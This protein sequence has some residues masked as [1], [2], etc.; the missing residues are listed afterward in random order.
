[1][2]TQHFIP[3]LSLLSMLPCVTHAQTYSVKWSAFSGGGGSIGK[4]SHKATAFLGDPFVGSSH[5][6]IYTITSGFGS[7]LG[8]QPTAGAPKLSLSRGF[9][10]VEVSWPRPAAGWVLETTSTLTGTATR[11]TEVSQPYQTDDTHVFVTFPIPGE[12]AYFRLR[13]P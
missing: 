13:K 9:G 10:F 12:N 11:W 1:M 6:G 2:K 5:G 3:L 7:V 4:G 8:I